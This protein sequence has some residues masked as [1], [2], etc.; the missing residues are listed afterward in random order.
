[1]K[2]FADRKFVVVLVSAM[3]L[4]ACNQTKDERSATAPTQPA[5]DTSTQVTTQATD[6]LAGHVWENIVNFKI[7]A[8]K[9]S[10]KDHAYKIK[11]TWYHRTAFQNGV[12]LQGFSQ[13]NKAQGNVYCDVVWSSK[14]WRA[15]KRFKEG[16]VTSFTE[17]KTSWTFVTNSLNL[18]RG[19]A[20]AKDGGR[21]REIECI[22][23][24]STPLNLAD[25]QR[26]LG[27]YV[28]IDPK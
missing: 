2:L 11:Y 19:T 15:S 22:K 14:W 4:L 18:S 21:I 3:S 27:S 20:K 10:D 26:A 1:M 6:P 28:R 5:V 23:H 13:V 17:A 25:V 8:L 12:S 16:E 9:E 24:D 7:T